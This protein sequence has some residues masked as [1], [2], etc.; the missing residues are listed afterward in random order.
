MATEAEYGKQP[1][2]DSSGQRPISVG[3]P[4]ADGMVRP[5]PLIKG[6]LRTVRKALDD[7][8]GPDP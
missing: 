7:E 8:E 3:Y 6:K 1:S 5:I 4:G 2:V